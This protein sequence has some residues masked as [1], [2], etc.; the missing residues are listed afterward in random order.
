MKKS[1]WIYASLLG[2]IVI[3]WWSIWYQ[4]LWQE[5]NDI[6]FKTQSGTP[7]MWIEVE[8]GHAPLWSIIIKLTNHGTDIVN[9][10]SF[11]TSAPSWLKFEGDGR[12]DLVVQ[13]NGTSPWWSNIWYMKL[14]TK[15]N[16]W[17]RS[18]T[19]PHPSN[20][21]NNQV[22][23]WTLSDLKIEPGSSCI[24][25]IIL[26]WKVWSVDYQNTLLSANITNT[27]PSEPTWW[28]E[29]KN[30]YAENKRP[31]VYPWEYF[32]S[33]WKI[34]S[35]EKEM[36]FNTPSIWT[37]K[38]KW[39]DNLDT[40]PTGI[41]NADDEITIRLKV[42]SHWTEDIKNIVIQDVLDKW[43][44]YINNSLKL[45]EWESRCPTAISYI[46][47]KVSLWWSLPSPYDQ[48]TWYGYIEDIYGKPCIYEI[49]AK[50]NNNTM[51]TLFNNARI[52]QDINIKDISDIIYWRRSSSDVLICN[53]QEEITWDVLFEK[54]IW[55]CYN[56]DDLNNCKN[57]TANYWNYNI[58]GD[59]W[60]Y[61]SVP[62]TFLQ[63]GYHMQYRLHIEN[64][65][66]KSITNYEIRDTYIP[67]NFGLPWESEIENSDTIDTAF[68]NISVPSWCE[69]KKWNNGIR[70]WT[71]MVRWLWS[72]PN[73][74][75]K[76]S[77]YTIYCWEIKPW[78]VK[79]I[80]FWSKR[81]IKVL[82]MNPQCEAWLWQNCFVLNQ[83]DLYY[84]IESSTDLYSLDG[85]PIKVQ[86]YQQW[87]DKQ[88]ETRLI[89]ESSNFQWDDVSSEN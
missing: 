55:N 47:N 25:A 2:I 41:C 80:I 81:P 22:W 13:N 46:D 3:A 15:S 85:T 7:D 83:A 35:I 63:P 28:N 14:Y 34:I 69:I 87:P 74:I 36:F 17:C 1:N 64:N 11:T 4:F 52:I 18:K 70:W 19:D 30:N 79:D 40:S 31:M 43:M 24:Y 76:K 75:P 29:E 49:K 89:V 33:K 88:S 26:E 78:E 12:L 57:R 60:G 38:D 73:Y 68:D 32:I 8:F 53:N 16:Q 71:P 67:R 72:D 61:E 10:V 23:S 9:W 84:D 27:L 58:Q 56:W 54:Q 42:R 20:Q 21:W 82:K 77:S 44:S 6:S 37:W 66:N 50:F 48:K 5:K 86:P 59:Y 65:T 62:L 39:S 45:V 51:W